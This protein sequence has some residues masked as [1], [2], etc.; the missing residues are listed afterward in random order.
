MTKYTINKVFDKTFQNPIWKIEVDTVNHNLAIESRNPIDTRPTFHV[1]DFDGNIVLN[2]FIVEEKEWTLEA[3]QN[4]FLILKK[5]GSS[6][7]IQAGIQIVHIPTKSIVANF[8][9]YELKEVRKDSIVAVHRAIPSGLLFYIEMKSGK[10]S[11]KLE[12]EISFFESNIEYP[13]PYQGNLPAFM[14]NIT[15][16][17]QLWLQSCEDYFIWSFQQKNTNYYEQ[18]LILSSRNQIFKHIIIDNNLSKL[19]LQP[20]LKVKGYI[21]F[22][23]DT[24]QKIVTYLV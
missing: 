8:V 18:H 19:I 9:E 6:T 15:Y 22:L 5:L 21:F 1:L 16:H 20:Y 11:N 24:K 2:E 23:S 3:I 14:K 12:N 17:G 4:D 7:P 13:K 10:V